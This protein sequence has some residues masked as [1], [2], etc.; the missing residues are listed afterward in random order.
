MRIP[1]SWV[2]VMARE[3]VNKITKMDEV[4][5]KV[6]EEELMHYAEEI[7]LDELMAEDRVNEEVREILKSFEGEIEKKHLDYKGLF[8]L[9]KKKLIKE[10]NIVI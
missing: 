9:T 8:E 2:P 7:M 6:S 5:Y 3:I 1:K 10:R 4:D